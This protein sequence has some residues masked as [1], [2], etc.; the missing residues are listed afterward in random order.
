MTAQTRWS[1]NGVC[2]S[3]LRPV[4]GLDIQNAA[5]I[6]E[7]SQSRK[8]Q[9]LRELVEVNYADTETFQYMIQYLYTGINI[10]R[11]NF[12]IN[13]SWQDTSDTSDSR[14]YRT[15]ALPN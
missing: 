12:V 2:S 13:H 7:S 4:R 9:E 8:I 14:I 5:Q 10:S 11:T 6:G 15:G 3:V 1:R